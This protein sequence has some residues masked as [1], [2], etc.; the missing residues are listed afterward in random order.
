MTPARRERMIRIPWVA[1][2]VAIFTFA[3]NY[4]IHPLFLLSGVL[5]ASWQ[6]I[7]AQWVFQGLIVFMGS[8]LGYPR[9]VAALGA[10]PTA[11]AVAVVPA[12]VTIIVWYVLDEP[13]SALGASGVA[14]VV[15]GM[16]AG[17][18]RTRPREPARA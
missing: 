10:T 5:Q 12:A 17:G 1:A 18:V 8:T 11:T 4:P 6:E 9:A 15:I 13:R 3:L 2:I 16:M 14:V 7:G